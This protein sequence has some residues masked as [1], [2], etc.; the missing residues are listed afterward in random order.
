MAENASVTLE[1]VMNVDMS[2]MMYSLANFI[3]RFGGASSHRIKTKYCSLCETV[4]ARSDTLSIRKDSPARYELLNYILAW[5][6][7]PPVREDIFDERC[8]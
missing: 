6:S 5:M 3:D 2:S 7:P 4:C 8:Y 1:D